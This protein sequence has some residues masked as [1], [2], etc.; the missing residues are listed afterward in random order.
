MQETEFAEVKGKIVSGVFALTTRTLILQIISFIAT[1]ILTILLTPAVF[2]VFFVVSAVISFLSY[3]SDIGLAAAL[4]Q[5]KREPT[6][7]ELACVFTLQQLLIGSIVV[8]GYLLSPYFGSFYKLD[9]DGIFLLQTLLISFFLSSLWFGN[10][11][12]CLC[13]SC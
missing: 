7:D 4:I 10:Q 6:Q 8:G 9:T 12:F 13:L 3:F 5:K 1:F 2:G 11:E